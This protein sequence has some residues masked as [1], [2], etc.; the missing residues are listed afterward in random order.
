M[1]PPLAVSTSRYALFAARATKSAALQALDKLIFGDRG[2][3][4]KAL[5]GE[6]DSFTRL[7]GGENALIIRNAQTSAKKMLHEID[8]TNTGFILEERYIKHIMTA[9]RCTDALPFSRKYGG[10]TISPPPHRSAIHRMLID[11]P[12]D[13][14][15]KKRAE[16]LE[17][18]LAI[19]IVNGMIHS[20]SSPDVLSKIYARSKIF[21][22]LKYTGYMAMD[23]RGLLPKIEE[24][25]GVES[26]E[27]A[28]ELDRVD[29]S[30]YDKC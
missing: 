24:M 18:A 25:P 26:P 11:N 4:A 10:R 13:Y 22:L 12:P 30:I 17:G 2:V 23:L 1:L 14:Y 7:L 3:L 20:S 6:N 28:P 29:S 19:L 21:D 5:S 16:A 27:P 8:P 9:V 15:L